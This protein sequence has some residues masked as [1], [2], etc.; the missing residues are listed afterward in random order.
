[1]CPNDRPAGRQEILG[2]SN[3]ARIAAP[4]SHKICLGFAA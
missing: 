3:A 1:M 4:S 2:S